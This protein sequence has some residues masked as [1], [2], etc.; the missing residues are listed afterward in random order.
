[1]A[2]KIP[3]SYSFTM[4]T[5][6]SGTLTLSLGLGKKLESLSAYIEE[7]NLGP[8]QVDF[9]IETE[10]KKHQIG[11]PTVIYDGEGHNA[12]RF[13][14]NIGIPLSRFVPSKLFLNWANYCGDDVTVR[15]A[16]FKER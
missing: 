14:W 10:G 8:V 15:I 5:A 4:S 3:F 7:D 13:E 16:G 9:Y 6:N 1:M 2:R 12:V 11:Q